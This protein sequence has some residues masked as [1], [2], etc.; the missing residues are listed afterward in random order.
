MECRCS[1]QIGSYLDDELRG[2]ARAA[3]EAHLA[4]CAACRSQLEE[5]TRLGNLLRAAPLPTVSSATLTRIQKRCRAAEDERRVARVAAWLTAAAAVVLIGA[6]LPPMGG[7]TDESL[8]ASSDLWQLAA[9]NPSAAMQVGA[10]Q[11][12]ILL[13]QWMAEDLSPVPQR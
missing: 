5:L 2:E 13:A 11:D 10:E 7:A 3:F 9:V 6:L 4:S 1:S 12:P 8:A